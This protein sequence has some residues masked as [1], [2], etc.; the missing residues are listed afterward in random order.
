[1][2]GI[3]RALT[4]CRGDRGGGVLLVAGQAGAVIGTSDT[5]NHYANVG[6]LQ[7]H[8]GND[9]FD[10]CSGTLVRSD[11]VLTAALCTALPWRA[12]RPRRSRVRGT[13]TRSI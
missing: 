3:P 6:V 7:L 1:M 10:F 2:R 4:F 5:E 8:V 9:W 13:S 11:V 12:F